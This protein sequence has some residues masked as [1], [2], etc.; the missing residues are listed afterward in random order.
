MLATDDRDAMVAAVL[1]GAGIMPIGMFDPALLASGALRRVLTGWTCPGGP[2]LVALYRCTSRPVPK[3]ALFLYFV[4][5]A[6]ADFDCEGV[7]L[8]P[9]RR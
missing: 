9:T 8:T 4:A 2:V 6:V 3:V 5:A 1:A 7:T